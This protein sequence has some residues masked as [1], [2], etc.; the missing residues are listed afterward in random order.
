VFVAGRM[1]FRLFLESYGTLVTVSAP[2]VMPM[3]DSDIPM[4]VPFTFRN[5]QPF[6]QMPCGHRS[7]Q[8]LLFK[9]PRWA[10]DRGGA[11]VALTDTAD[12]ETNGVTRLEPSADWELPVLHWHGPTTVAVFH[13]RCCSMSSKSTLNQEVCLI[14]CSPGFLG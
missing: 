9:P 13:D 4:N 1:V 2:L 5:K 10:I 14:C 8:L 11:T 7:L 6:P 12:P 3:C